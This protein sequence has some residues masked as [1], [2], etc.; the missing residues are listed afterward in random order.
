[1]RLVVAIVVAA[2]AVS[3]LCLGVAG[4]EKTPRKLSEAEMKAIVG[5]IGDGCPCKEDSEP[6]EMCKGPDGCHTCRHAYGEDPDD[7]PAD[8]RVYEDFTY[9]DCAGGLVMPL[10]CHNITEEPVQCLAQY[11][12]KQVGIVYNDSKCIGWPEGSGEYQ[13]ADTG[14][15]SDGWRC[16]QCGKDGPITD[17]PTIIK[18]QPQRCW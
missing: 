13:C 16:R 10:T 11:T 7:C 12:C 17:P 2:C 4:G 8:A 6:H 5:K 1:M 14:Q 18:V 15:S 9:I 3:F